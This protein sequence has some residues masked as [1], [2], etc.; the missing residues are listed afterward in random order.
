LF[1]TVYSAEVE[2]MSRKER[3]KQ[4]DKPPSGAFAFISF[5]PDLIQSAIDLLHLSLLD[6]Q[7]HAKIPMTHASAHGAGAIEL[8]VTA[9]DV[10]MSETLATIAF[11][12]YDGTREQLDKSIAEKYKFLYKHF[13]LGSVGADPPH[14]DD[15]QIVINVRNEIVHHFIRP[16][17]ELMPDWLPI[18][19][20]R[21]LLI[22]GTAPEVDFSLSVK[23]GSYALAYWVFEV[24]ESC[25]KVFEPRTSK[26][27]VQNFSRYRAI[28]PPSKLAS[29]DEQFNEV[30]A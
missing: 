22:E 12:P 20:K 6:R 26:N 17:P 1:S 15:L 21:G 23:L 14:L 30:K 7:K 25:V 28:C 3:L 18:L 11:L 8:A 29:F 5:Y 10:W 24:I 13:R 16:N 27:H 9:F 2:Q 19:R 4:F